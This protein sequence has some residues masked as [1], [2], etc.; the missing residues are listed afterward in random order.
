MSLFTQREYVQ[1]VNT[2]DDMD[3]QQQLDHLRRELL[4]TY[5]MQE[6]GVTEIQAMQLLADCNW[7]YK[8][9]ITNKI[10][11]TLYSE[12]GPSQRQPLSE[13]ACNR[14]DQVQIPPTNSPSSPNPK[15]LMQRLSSVTNKLGSMHLTSNQ[16]PS[17]SGA[18]SSVNADADQLRMVDD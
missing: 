9:A 3:K 15:E 4:I 12:L 6:S 11:Q 8:L 1:K 2:V 5:F 17:T 16:K 18:H 7:N 10:N 14:N 13:L